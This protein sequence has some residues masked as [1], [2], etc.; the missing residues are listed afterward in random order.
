MS[1]YHKINSIFKRDMQSKHKQ[2]IVGDWSTDE[3]RYLA[4]TNWEFSEKIDGMNIRVVVT[5]EDITFRGRTDNAVLPAQLIEKLRQKFLPR[6][7]T[8]RVA[9]PNG[10]IFYGEGY[11]GKI[12]KG[13]YYRPDPDFILFDIRVGHVWLQRQ[14]IVAIA[15]EYE[16][17]VV[18]ILGYGTLHAAV[19]WA[20]KGIPSAICSAQSE[21]IV[22]RPS[23][24]ILSRKGERII[25]K[26]K[27]CDFMPPPENA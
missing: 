12:Q 25:A 26:I 7:E 14:D 16:L 8:L 22:A 11:G 6:M 27:C 13:S 1:E 2:L 10:V 9:F 18:P 4:D 20:Q 24:G 5:P 15:Q 19:N 23:V 21:G 3:F 17:D